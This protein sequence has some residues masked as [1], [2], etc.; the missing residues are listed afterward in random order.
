[1]IKKL[2][3]IKDYLPFLLIIFFATCLAFERSFSSFT[4]EGIKM[5]FLTLFPSLFPYL[6]VTAMLSFVKG[7][8]IIS[9]LL[10]PFFSRVFKVNGTCGYAYFISLISG[11]PVGAITVS[12]LKKNNQISEAEAVRASILCS[13][14]SPSF[15]V[16][17]V[18][19][20]CFNSTIVGLF[21]FLTHL[22]SS[23]TVGLI[24]SR[25]KKDIT[26]T[27]LTV[28]EKINTD[29][30][31]Y[32][33]IISTVNSALFVGGLVTLFYV[34]TE[35]LYSLKLLSLPINLI[36]FIVSNEEIGKAIVFGLFE[37]TKGI[38]LL[39][40]ISPSSLT[41]CVCSFLCGFSGLSVI[42]QSVCY[43]KT[44]KIK[45]VPF[46]LSKV[47]SAVFNLFYSFIFSL[48]LF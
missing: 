46:L 41:F 40:L 1:M 6:F 47:F 43:L 15:L 45:T 35:I 14:S 3:K 26:P 34:F 9:K 27:P 16:T 32:E 28:N 18:G 21:L 13:T 30:F 23:I 4:I 48:L 17:V 8:D 10:S 7:G 12:R 38:K 39:S 42:L 22:L 37:P 33:G 36:S 5:Y 20:I 2:I 19:A 29:N 11:Y 44:A 24:F 31:I 25:Y